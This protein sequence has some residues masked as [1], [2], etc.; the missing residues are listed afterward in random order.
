MSRL[1]KVFIVLF[2]LIMVSISFSFADDISGFSDA[3]LLMLP[4]S[5]T[6]NKN[7]AIE[8]TQKKAMKASDL[9]DSPLSFSARNSN[10]ASKNLAVVRFQDTLHNLFSSIYPSNGYRKRDYESYWYWDGSEWR[11]VKVETDKMFQSDNSVT[12]NINTT[13]L[14]T[15]E[16]NPSEVRDFSLS[17]F[18][19]EAYVSDD[20]SKYTKLNGFPKKMTLGETITL[21]DGSSTTYFKSLGGS[22]YQLYIPSTP[23][24]S[25]SATD[26]YYPLLMRIFDICVELPDTDTTLS[27]GTYKT[28]ISLQS[29]STYTNKTFT[30]KKF[31]D[32][33]DGGY[34]IYTSHS[35]ISLSE[36]ITIWGYVGSASTTDSSS[37][38]FSVA[39]STDSYSMNLGDTDTYYSVA[40]VNFYNVTG[41]YTSDSEPSEST[42][43]EKYKIYLSPTSNYLTSGSYVFTKTTKKQDET[44]YETI[45]YDIYLDSSGTEFSSNSTT[46]IGGSGVGSG[47][48]PATT[49][50]IFPNYTIAKEIM[51]N[52]TKYTE[53]WKVSNLP[54]Y[55]K[56]STDGV[57]HTEGEYKSNLYF[58]VVSN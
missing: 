35:T 6:Y 21:S 17:C 19:T 51:N 5:L 11:R 44:D 49:Y 50:Y 43:K 4:R 13:G 36:N 54:I 37:F 8:M 53:T 52:S 7:D 25:T 24:V 45:P 39:P 38:S 16:D 41:P 56:V 12:I 18:V 30:G 46:N 27:E 57:N 55:L 31:L 1:K 20:G 10:T 40:S 48:I 34:N 26:T 14:F 28:E 2:F 3:V 33:N 58:T 42:Q 47:T 15:N 29:T 23:I 9:G 32:E 22:N